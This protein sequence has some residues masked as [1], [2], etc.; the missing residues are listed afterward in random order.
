MAVRYLKPSE[1][2]YPL[3][4]SEH[5]IKRIVAVVE[6]SLPQEAVSFEEMEAYQDLLY[7]TIAAKIQTHE[8]SRA[9]Q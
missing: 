1:M 3:E 4:L 2:N 9:L 5:D 7:D 8:G 6:G